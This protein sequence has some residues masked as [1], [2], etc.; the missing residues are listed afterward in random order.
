MKIIFLIALMVGLILQLSC[1]SEDPT[2]PVDNGEKTKL[3]KVIA[4]GNSLTAGVQSGGLLDDFQLHSYPYLIAAQIGRSNEFQQPLIAAPGL[5][6]I[7]SVSG[8]AYGPLKFENG[9]IVSGDP[10]SGGL[11]G[12]TALLTNAVLP[13]A[14]DNLGLP[15]ADVHDILT[16][17]GGGIYDLV[18]RNPYFGNSTALDQAKSLN[19]TLILLWAGNN[20]VLGAAL[21]GGNPSLIT[22]LPEFRSDYTSI[23]DELSSINDSSVVLIV[24]NIPNVSDIPYVNLLDNLIYRSVPEIGLNTPVPVVFDTS[25]QPILFDTF[26][27]PLLTEESSAD[28][29]HVLLSFL[30]EYSENGMGIPDSLN[31]VNLGFSSEQAGSIMQYLLSKDLQV[32]GNP[33][34][35]SMTLTHSEKVNIENAVAGFNQVIL[36]LTQAR[37]IP[38]VDANTALNQLNSSG[39]DGYSGKFVYFDVENTAFSLDGIHPNNGGY[40]II[41]NEFIRVMNQ[42]PDIDIPLLNTADFKGQYNGMQPRKITRKATDQARAFFVK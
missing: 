18:L 22:P 39:I 4:I 5:A 29:S 28:I 32:S 17:T 20:D 11:T 3:S 13:R 1:S 2:Q 36:E 25:F 12:I 27:V 10:V 15:G 37:D 8:M 23:L 38:L 19:P 26:Y 9:Q 6:Q 41:A 21:D 24:A 40:A 14:Y 7:D 42:F 35:A 34:P 31:L 33:V 30:S 16:A